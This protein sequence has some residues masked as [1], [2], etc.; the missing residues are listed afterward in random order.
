MIKTAPLALLALLAACT[1][2]PHTASPAVGHSAPPGPSRITVL[3]ARALDGPGA[4]EL[5]DHRLEV[6]Y[7]DTDDG[8]RTDLRIDGHAFTWPATLH[9]CPLDPACT[10]ATAGDAVPTDLVLD[11]ARALRWRDD[12]YLWLEGSPRACTGLACRMR[13]YVFAAVDLTAAVALA[14]FSVDEAAAE[15]SGLQGRLT[16]DLATAAGPDEAVVSQHL[17]GATLGT[18]ALGR[19]GLPSPP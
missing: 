2:P 8:P 19:S 4:Y 7:V 1:R 13:F 5:A 11:H 6:T 14:T 15:V 3:A 12:D 18:L 16:I 10:A 9:N 17:E